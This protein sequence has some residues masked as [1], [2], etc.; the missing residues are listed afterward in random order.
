MK[1]LKN[2]K[3]NEL[4]ALK[5]LKEKLL[6]RFKDIEIILYGSKVRGDFDDES[7]I[8]LLLLVDIPVDAK[9]EEEISEIVYEIELKY[10]VIFGKIIENKEFWNSKLAR[11][12][13]FHQN[14]DK[15][16]IKL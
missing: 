8:D 13:P 15:E 3:E 5:E 14:V 7:D 9:V 10:D 2:L 12:M 4:N 6:E 11:A 1:N 16:G